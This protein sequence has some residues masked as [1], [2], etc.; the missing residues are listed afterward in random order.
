MT[1]LRKCVILSRNISSM[2]I[3]LQLARIIAK[4][5]QG[6]KGHIRNLEKLALSIFDKMKKISGLGERQRLLLQIAVILH[7]CGKYINLI[8]CKLSVLTALLWQ[9]RL[10]G[11]PLRKE[12]LLPT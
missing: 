2:M 9:Q 10:L 6:N 3:S 5:Y 1:M 4:R 12:A 11:C 8:R 7:G